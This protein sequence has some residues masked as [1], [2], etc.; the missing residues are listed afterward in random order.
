MSHENPFRDNGTL[1][2]SAEK[3]GAIFTQKLQGALRSCLEHVQGE[4]RA[5]VVFALEQIGQSL[6]ERVQGRKG[7]KPAAVHYS[8]ISDRFELLVGS[9]SSG[10]R[11]FIHMKE[12]DSFPHDLIFPNAETVAYGTTQKSYAD[13]FKELFGERCVNRGTNDSPYFVVRLLGEE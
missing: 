10:K 4:Q 3:E 1:E 11:M 2:H 8:A 5:E 13:G 12:Y 7:V 6:E 9:G